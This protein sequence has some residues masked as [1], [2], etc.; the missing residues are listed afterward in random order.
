MLRRKKI[1]NARPW[2]AHWEVTFEWNGMKSREHE[3]QITGSR[4]WYL[5]DRYVTNPLIGKSWVDAFR[6]KPFDSFT[7]FYPERIGK[8]RKARPVVKS[9][10][11]ERTAKPARSS[12]K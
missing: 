11:N 4:E 12:A 10:A 3:F 2:P 7:S 8:I 5:F 6:Q 1:K 9:V